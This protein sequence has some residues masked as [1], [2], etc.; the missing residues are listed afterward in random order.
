MTWIQESYLNHLSTGLITFFIYKDS[1]EVTELF[2]FTN[3]FTIMSEIQKKGS[4]F[5]QFVFSRGLD[6]ILLC[7]LVKLIKVCKDG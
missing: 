6:K 5:R 3:Y 2:T 4:C 7:M 1:F